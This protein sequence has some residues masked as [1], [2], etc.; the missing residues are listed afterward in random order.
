M[1]G[2]CNWI[3][4][5]RWVGLGKYLGPRLTEGGIRHRRRRRRRRWGIAGIAAVAGEI[6]ADP[7]ILIAGDTLLVTLVSI[8]FKC[9]LGRIV[10]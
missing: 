8:L 7:L 4:N 1:S 3:S 10:L 9:T 5:R 6:E 2:P